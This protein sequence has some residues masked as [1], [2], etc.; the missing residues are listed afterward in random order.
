M[1]SS[2]SNLSHADFCSQVS[3]YITQ[4]WPSD[5]YKSRHSSTWDAAYFPTRNTKVIH[6][7][8]NGQDPQKILPR[9]NHKILKSSK[10]PAPLS[11]NGLTLGWVC[12]TM[13]LF[14]QTSLIITATLTHITTVLGLK[15]DSY[16]AACW[17][18]GSP[19]VDTKFACN[20]GH[21]G[22][23]CPTGYSGIHCATALRCS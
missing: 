10:H 1:G 22:D 2:C 4:H 13:K 16:C 19:G 15:C 6:S 5:W 17:K 7:L 8:P 21:C 18:D 20:S 3:I 23:K 11:G 14:L 9:L 12:S